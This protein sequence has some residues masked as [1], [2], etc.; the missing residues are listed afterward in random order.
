MLF[1][2]KNF[3]LVRKFHPIDQT[4]KLQSLHATVSTQHIYGVQLHYGYT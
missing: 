4:H 1:E 3:A 2:L